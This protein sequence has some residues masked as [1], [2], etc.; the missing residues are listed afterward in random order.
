MNRTFFGASL[1][2]MG[3]L[4]VLCIVWFLQFL[5]FTDYFESEG[6]TLGISVGQALSSETSDDA[7]SDPDTNR[8]YP[9]PLPL[10][11]NVRQAS[12]VGA[13][14]FVGL[15]QPPILNARAEL[16]DRPFL[17]HASAPAST[18]KIKK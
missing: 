5:S 7:D 9:P 10:Q 2:A 14:R 18:V 12:L 3:T 13:M 16:D 6:F 17:R 8:A 15:K 1:M 4:A 11:G